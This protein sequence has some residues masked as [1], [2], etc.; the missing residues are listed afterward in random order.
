[1]PVV[2]PDLLQK[3]LV[4]PTRFR[5]VDQGSLQ[6]RVEQALDLFRNNKVSGEKLVI[7]IN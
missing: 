3:G 4:Q 7:K 5:V 6:Q 2:L 1:M